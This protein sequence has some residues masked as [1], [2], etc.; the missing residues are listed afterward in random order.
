MTTTYRVKGRSIQNVCVA[1]VGAVGTVIAHHLT[2]SFLNLSV[3]ARGA[4]LD[5]VRQRGLTLMTP[6]GNDTAA[7]RASDGSDLPAQDLIFLCVKAHD[8]PD[9]AK[10]LQ[11]LLH[12][13][14]LIVPVVNGVPFWFFQG[15]AGPASNQ[16]VHSVDPKG[17]LTDIFPARNIVGASAMIIAERVGPGISQI[18]NPPAMTIGNITAHQ[19]DEARVVAGILNEC[20][21]TTKVTS[22][23]RTAVWRK[24]CAN[25]ASNPLSVLAECTIHDI[26][27]D[28]N[29]LKVG[30][31]LFLEGLLLGS[32]LDVRDLETSGLAQVLRPLSDFKTS[33]LQDYEAGRPLEL[34]AICDAVIELAGVVGQPVPLTRQISCL[35]RHKALSR[36]SGFVGEMQPSAIQ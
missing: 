34:D 6:L 22:S 15:G 20:G 27:D 17:D 9:L 3:L 12:A 4:T 13:D 18:T 32:L 26:R 31:A 16:T 2:D 35:T 29:L 5:L 8:L 1:G 36:R 33:M 30:D 21:L 11:P 7:V 14:T 23:I 25:L 28:P 24:L 19:E 10:S